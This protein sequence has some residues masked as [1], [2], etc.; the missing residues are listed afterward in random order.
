MTLTCVSGYWK[1][2]NKHGEKFDNWFH[3]TLQINCPY[4]FFSDKETIEMIKKYRGDLPTHYIECRIEDFY[5]YQYRNKMITDPRHCPSIELN[6][7]WNEKIF[8][9]QKAAK[10]N[11]FISSHFMWIDA[12]ICT[13]RNNSPPKTPFPNLVKLN[14]L[15]KDKFI[16]TSCP[17]YNPNHSCYYNKMTYVTGTFILHHSMIDNFVVIYKQYLDKL[18]DKSMVWTDQVILTHIYK[19]N[20]HL[21]YKL[22]EGWGAI[23]PL[24]Y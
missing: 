16:F 17:K 18:I 20:K 9:I 22:C 1:I 8:L 3:N 15:P 24:L 5:T 21:F 2:K 10:L 7:I 11:P 6:L 12:G 13:F 19:D 14:Y 4:V 23:I